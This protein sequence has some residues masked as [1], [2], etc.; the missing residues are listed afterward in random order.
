MRFLPIAAALCAIGFLSC[1]YTKET[2]ARKSRYSRN[3]IFIDEIKKSSA[4]NAFDLIETLRPYWL[5][6]RGPKSVR[7]EM[8][9]YPVV[10]VD[11]MRHGNI[12]SL[13]TIPVHNIV[14]IQYMNAGDAT[15]RFGLDHP[16]GAILITMFY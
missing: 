11:G 1:S 14:E 5:G 13:T 6:G 2:Y 16:S 7:D 10:Y 12:K 4:T 15:I 8:A 3:Y 9:S